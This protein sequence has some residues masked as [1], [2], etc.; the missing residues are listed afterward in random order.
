MKGQ[1]QGNH[2]AEKQYGLEKLLGQWMAIIDQIKKKESEG[3]Y[4]AALSEVIRRPA[5]YIDMNAGCGWNHEVDCIGS[6]LM[7]MD[8]HDACKSDIKAF[9]LEKETTSIDSLLTRLPSNSGVYDVIQCNSEE[10]ILNIIQNQPKSYGLIY[11][12]PNGMPMFDSIREVSR[13]PKC[14]FVDL[15]IRISGTNYKRIRR[16]I[17]EYGKK[18]NIPEL[19]NKYPNLESQLRSVN[20]KEWLIRDIVDPDPQQW[21]FL[22]GTNW[23]NYPAW[24]KHGF[25]K[26]S[27][28]KGN[29]ILKRVCYTIEELNK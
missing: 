8:L 4:N 28:S 5:L 10:E 12:D 22:F 3:K 13:H 24:E 26:I 23:T 16:G 9:F 1:G 6:P 2:T 7:F 21:T 27:S 29:A 25:Y 15:L 19:I 18:N 11:H 14:R 20:K 17:D